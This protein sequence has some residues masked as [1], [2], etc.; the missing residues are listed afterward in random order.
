MTTIGKS[1]GNV[2]R[3]GAYLHHP[4]QAEWKHRIRCHRYA[5]EIPSASIGASQLIQE[6]SYKI[7]LD[8][9]D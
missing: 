9:L 4:Y 2:K 6:I 8:R 7:D 3:R 1:G 5:R